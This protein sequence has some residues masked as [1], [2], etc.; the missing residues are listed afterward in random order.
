MTIYDLAKAIPNDNPDKGVI[1]LQAALGEAEAL[2]EDIR[3]FI[4]NLECVKE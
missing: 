3:Q 2:R 4:E 1:L